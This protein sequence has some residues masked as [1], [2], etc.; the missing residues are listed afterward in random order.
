MRTTGFN[1]QIFC[2]LI[3]LRL[4]VL[5]DCHKKQQRMPYTPLTDWFL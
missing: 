2:M 4:C 5:C 1:I 3:T